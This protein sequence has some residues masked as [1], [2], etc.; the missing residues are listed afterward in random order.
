MRCDFLLALL[1]IQILFM[2]LN[3]WDDWNDRHD[4]CHYLETSQ[5]TRPCVD[6]SSI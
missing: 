4:L 1:I 5:Q 6:L 2:A 3:I